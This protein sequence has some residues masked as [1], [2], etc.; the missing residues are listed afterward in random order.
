MQVSRY[1]PLELA[2]LHEGPLVKR[3]YA[4]LNTPG[5][6]VKMVSHTL[7]LSVDHTSDLFLLAI[8]LN[9]LS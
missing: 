4:S 9:L 5:D 8:C 3:G 6:T 2:L 7:M 1:D